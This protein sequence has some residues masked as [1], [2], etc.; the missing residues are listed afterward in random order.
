MT[1]ARI[2]RGFLVSALAFAAMSMT[3]SALA[4]P[5]SGFTD[6]QN[7]DAQCPSVDWLRNRAITLGCTSTTLYCPSDPVIRLAMAA[8]MNRLGN[9]LTPVF[10]YDEKSG[11]ALDISTQSTICAA[12]TIP[13]AVYSRSVHAGGVMSALTSGAAMPRL[14][15][16]VS[17]D[18]GAT[19]SST[20]AVAPTANETNG[21]LNLTVWSSNIVLLPATSYRVGLRV[22]SASGLGNFASWTCQ[23]QAMVVSRTGTS[24][25][26]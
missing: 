20:T 1:M 22:Q 13:T 26:Y 4:A 14:D 8:F 18:G 2:A 3:S 5:C 16:V 12:Q 24:A 11:A 15:V 10:Y 9:A 6:V 17:T 19:W 21:Y 23:V 25:P 7:T